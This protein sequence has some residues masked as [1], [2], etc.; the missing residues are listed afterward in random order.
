MLSGED[1]RTFC[2]T[3]NTWIAARSVEKHAC[4]IR[5]KQ[6]ALREALRARTASPEDELLLWLTAFGP[7]E[8]DD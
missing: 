4:F 7:P 5:A 3:C 2:G 6:E 8:E 1:D